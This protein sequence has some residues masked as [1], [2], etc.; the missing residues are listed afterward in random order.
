M[1]S[2]VP[3]LVYSIGYINASWTLRSEITAEFVCRILNQMAKLKASKVVPNIPE[4]CMLETSQTF[5]GDFTPGYIIRGAHLMA[6]QGKTDPWRFNQNYTLDKKLIRN[7]KLED[8][9]LQF[10]S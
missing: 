4:D 8:G 1:F 5:I 10:I 7:G 3:N 9:T 2:G 6:K